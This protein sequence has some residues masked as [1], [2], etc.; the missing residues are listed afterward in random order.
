VTAKLSG[1]ALAAASEDSIVY[2][3][4]NG[5][6][7]AYGELVRRRQSWLRNLL[8]RLSRDAAL[9]D[10]LAQQAFLQGWHSIRQLKSRAAL[11]AWLRRLAVNCWLQHLRRAKAEEPLEED[12]RAETPLANIDRR[13]DLDA[14]LACLSAEA[15]LCVVLAYNEGMSHAEIAASTSIPLGTVK[16]HVTRGAAR[17]RELLIGYG[18]RHATGT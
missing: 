14:A 13:M 18:E 17:L 10:D 7:S 4:V 2:L 11:G 5:D 16:S 6:N 15:R 3:A 1:S 8:L 9:A 12:F